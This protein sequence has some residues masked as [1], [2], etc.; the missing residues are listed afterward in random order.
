ME[1][2]LSDVAVMAYTDAV[3]EEI[4]H[5]LNASCDGFAERRLNPFQ[6]YNI[7]KYVE[8]NGLKR[9]VN[10]DGERTD[11][12]GLVIVDRDCTGVTYFV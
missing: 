5:A 12:E 7:L 9:T 3:A 11:G 6:K 8:D 1:Y 4:A 2:T 10:T